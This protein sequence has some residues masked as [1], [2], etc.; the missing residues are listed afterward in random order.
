MTSFGLGKEAAALLPL[1]N[2]AP[3]ASLTMHPPASVPPLTSGSGVA[4]AVISC[5]LDYNNAGFRGR[6][7]ASS[8][9]N[10]P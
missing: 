8:V 3:T 6:V 1:V 10:T 9:E 4:L 5:S 2:P 7:Q